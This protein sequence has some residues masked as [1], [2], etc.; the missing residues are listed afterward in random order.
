M[1][2][3]QKDSSYRSLSIIF[4]YFGFLIGNLFGTFLNSLRNRFLENIT[5]LFSILI[6]FE[7]LNYLIYDKRFFN[8]FNSLKNLQYSL[9]NLQFGIL[10]GFFIDAY[11][12]GS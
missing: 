6:L 5:V 2:V 1:L 7:I 12:I 8:K 11:K 9:K 10:L 3:K 4:F